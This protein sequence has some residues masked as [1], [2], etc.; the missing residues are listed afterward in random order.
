MYT[1]LLLNW[2]EV[3]IGYFSSVSS[4]DAVFV[5][6]LF[7]ISK[8]ITIVTWLICSKPLGWEFCLSL[9][10]GGCFQFHLNSF[11]LEIA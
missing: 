6:V 7:I 1:L 3:L 8:G 2:I 4:S 9:D 11:R 10:Y 5:V